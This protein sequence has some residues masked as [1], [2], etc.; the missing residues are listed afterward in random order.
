MRTVTNS[1]NM[2]IAGLQLRIDRD[3][4]CV[5]GHI[6]LRNPVMRFCPGGPGGKVARDLAAI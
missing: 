3:K 1:E 2:R 4:S 6:D 5:Q